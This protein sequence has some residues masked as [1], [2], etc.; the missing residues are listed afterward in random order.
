MDNNQL[1]YAETVCFELAAIRRSLS[2]FCSRVVPALALA[3]GIN[4]VSLI[5]TIILLIGGF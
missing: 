3:L 2:D 1:M 5:L 4:F